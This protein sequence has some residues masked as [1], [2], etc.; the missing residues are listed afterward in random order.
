MIA[1]PLPLVAIA[2]TGVTGQ[3]TPPA[4]VSPS[5]VP[6]RISFFGTGNGWVGGHTEWSIDRSG[7]GF[8]RTTIRQ[9]LSGKFKVGPEGFDRIRAILQPLES[10]G[11]LPC[12]TAVTDQGGGL[13]RWSRGK[14]ETS[15]RFEFGCNFRQSD[16][17]REQL[18]QA[19]ELVKS[20]A[21]AK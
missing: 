2:L 3:S 11:K 6:D 18:V 16:P 21:L 10:V 4:Q 1:M 8:Y 15:L 19:S 14:A 13:L 5:A 7:R 9:N 12:E 17:A 20:W